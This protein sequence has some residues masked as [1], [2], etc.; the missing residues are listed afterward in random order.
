MCHVGP[1]L[2]SVGYNMSIPNTSCVG[3]GSGIGIQSGGVPVVPVGHSSSGIGTQSSGGV[4][5]VP[6]GHSSSGIGVQSGGVPVVPV[7]H[8]SS[9][10]GGVIVP[11]TTLTS[12]VAVVLSSLSSVTTSSTSYLPGFTNVCVTLCSSASSVSSPKSQLYS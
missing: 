4:P 5:V 12:M 2:E 6:S 7:G 3:S 9:G 8:S 11:F 1:P 10:G